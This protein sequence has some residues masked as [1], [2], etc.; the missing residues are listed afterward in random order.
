LLEVVRNATLLNVAK[1]AFVGAGSVEFTR[2]VVTDLCG[3]P[4]LG[5]LQLALHDISAPRLEHAQALARRIVEQTGA[6]A[7]V[8]ASADRPEALDGASYVINEVQAGGYASTRLDFDIPARYGVRQT[9]G[10]TLG[11]GGIFRGLRTIPVVTGI[12]SDMVRLCP[13]AYL[14][15]YSN[16]MAMLPWA[17]YAGTSFRNVYGLCHS[18]RDTHSFLAGL[19]GVDEAQIRYVTA[20][21]NHQAFVLRF[22]HEGRSLYPRLAEI[23]EASPELQRRVRVEIFRRFGY[24]PTESSEHSAEYVPWFMRHDGEIDR[25][26]IFV[27]DYLARSEENLRELEDLQAQLESGAPLDLESSDELASQFIHSVE[28]GKAREIY[29]NVRNDGLISNLPADCCVEVPCAVDGDGARP[30]AVGAL[31]PQLAALNRTFLNVVEL[32]VRA[33][34]EG[35]RDHVYQAALLDPNTAATLT[36]GQIIAMCDDLLEAHHDLLP[37]GLAR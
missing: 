6:D 12:A 10:D 32:T 31:P 33:A 28:T 1:V 25:F 26:R 24:F 30:Q 29:V 14:L 22:E 17:V 36:T 27:G 8:T 13:D 21:F 19:V 3:Y 16:P 35:S 5:Q 4:E 11:I 34:L 18:V 37:P 15:N 9:I 2:N 23:I 7:I 20:G